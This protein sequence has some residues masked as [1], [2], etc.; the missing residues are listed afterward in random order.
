MLTVASI[1]EYLDRTRERFGMSQ[2]AV[3]AA[4]G[5]YRQLQ[6]AIE[7]GEVAD[8]DG[9]AKVAPKYDAAYK[10]PAGMTLAIAGQI[11]DRHGGLT[12]PDG[13]SAPS[14]TEVFAAHAEHPWHIRTSTLLG[15]VASGATTQIPGTRLPAI[16]TPI[17]V[18]TGETLLTNVS[19]P[20]LGPLT[21]AR[22]GLTLIDAAIDGVRRFAGLDAEPVDLSDFMTAARQE[23]PAGPPAGVQIGTELPTHLF[24][25]AVSLDPTRGLSDLTEA[26]RF[27]AALIRLYDSLYGGAGYSELKVAHTLLA[28][29]ACRGGLTGVAELAAGG[30]AFTSYYRNDYYRPDSMGPGVREPEGRIANLLRGLLDARDR[31]T[32]VRLPAYTAALPDDADPPQPECS[33]PPVRTA[34]EL[35]DADTLFLTYDSRISP[36]LP[37]VITRGLGRNVLSIYD[38]RRHSQRTPWGPGIVVADTLPSIGVTDADDA[39]VLTLRSQ[40][41][42]TLTHWNGET[43]VYCPAGRNRAFRVELPPQ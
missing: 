38:A 26:R 2:E 4:G 36:E 5:P 43:A 13:A 10:W 24:G 27:A 20:A 19:L 17:Y 11:A 28:L 41:V 6:A 34:D 39:S 9:I 22:T 37:V 16:G 14:Y 23:H 7:K 32:V 33:P 40:T 3:A 21:H 15:F 25:P 30:G 1:G 12:R 31:N 35:R 42:A 8:Y 18:D 29:A